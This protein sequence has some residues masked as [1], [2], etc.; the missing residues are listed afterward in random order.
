MRWAAAI[1]IAFALGGCGLDRSGVGAG[2]RA[3]AT[4]TDAEPVEDA[5]AD[6]DID[7]NE[8]DGAT[9]IAD[10]A[11]DG[12]GDAHDA[13]IDATDSAVSPCASGVV[14][15]GTCTAASTC[16]GCPGA[17]LFCAPTRTCMA[18]CA[19]CAEPGGVARPIECFACDAQRANPVGTCE[20]NDPNVYCLNDLYGTAFHCGCAPGGA[21]L[22]PS[23]VCTDVGFGVPACRTCGEKLSDG[24]ACTD[25]KTCK[26][27]ETKCD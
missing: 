6:S 27:A 15:N 2:D 26:A 3:D 7:V 8:S 11:E 9:P 23:Q 14:C 16:S 24:L 18:A 25:G 21:C 20:P 4:A 22:S 10:A 17:P 1:G 19:T 13:A 5:T 12:A